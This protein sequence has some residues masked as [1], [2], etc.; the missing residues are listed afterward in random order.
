MQRKGLRR[1]TIDK[2]YTKGSV[3]ELCLNHVKQYIKIDKSDLIIEPSAG[4]GA[5]IQG[6]KTLSEHCVFYDLEPENSEIVKQDYLMVDSNAFKVGE[7]RPIHVIGNPP[8]GRQSSMAIQFIKKSCEFCNTIA[9]I[10]PKSFKKDSLKK[11]FPLC[12][13]LVFEMDL[14]DKSFLVNGEEY[15][16]DSVFQIWERKSVDRVVA[17]KVE[18]V[19]FVFIEKNAAPDISVRRVGVYA[20]KIDTNSSEKSVQSHYFIKF[21]NNHSV[22]ENLEKLKSIE[23]SHNNTVGPRSISKQEL[24]VEFNRYL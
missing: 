3:V 11:T 16:V 12:F 8:F 6:I 2:Y 14:P 22:I 17:H 5:F 13:H 4:N 9:F 7:M 15:G 21:T 23:F 24:I 1:N 10:L 18:P 20:G 19:G